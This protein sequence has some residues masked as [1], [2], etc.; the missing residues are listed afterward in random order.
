MTQSQ[1]GREGILSGAHRG[2]RGEQG[3]R[4]QGDQ[5]QAHPGAPLAHEK[6]RRRADQAR[7]LLGER[8]QSDL[9]RA[10]FVSRAA[11]D[12]AII[13][14][15]S[16]RVFGGVLVQITTSEPVQLAAPRDAE[17]DEKALGVKIRAAGWQ[18][19]LETLATRVF[20]FAWQRFFSSSA[21]EYRRWGL[22]LRR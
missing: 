3:V 7:R 15:A 1:M 6:V 8:E 17:L 9:S 19:I 18:G 4:R 16:P 22:I 21:R 14:D 10:Q 5:A 13:V 20:L 2:G 12:L 11:R